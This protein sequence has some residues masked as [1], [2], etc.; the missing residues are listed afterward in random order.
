M[1]EWPAIAF[2]PF[3][4]IYFATRWR[5]RAPAI[6]SAQPPRFCS[7]EDFASKVALAM[8]DGWFHRLLFSSADA[9]RRRSIS[10]GVGPASRRRCLPSAAAINAGLTALLPLFSHLWRGRLLPTRP[11][12]MTK[13]FS[14]NTTPSPLPCAR[15]FF[16]VANTRHDGFTDVLANL[17]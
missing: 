9:T 7:R 3:T 2:A 1:L 4:F 5:R 13:G 11:Q 16:Y 12:T 17:F 8:R 15:R 6:S 14:A 10:S